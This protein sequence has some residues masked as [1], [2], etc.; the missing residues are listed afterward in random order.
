MDFRKSSPIGRRMKGVPDGSESPQLTISSLGG[1][2]R[3]P[4][5][6][7]IRGMV[8]SSPI[9][10]VQ[11]WQRRLQDQRMSLSE[12]KDP[13]SSRLTGS[14]RPSALRVALALLRLHWQCVQGSAHHGRPLLWLSASRLPLCVSPVST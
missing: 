2:S 5:Q 11:S 14:P 3:S 10:F 8:Q 7:G 12:I 1:Q 9:A 13:P 6:P 4:P